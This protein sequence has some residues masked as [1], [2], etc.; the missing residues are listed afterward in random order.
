MIRKAKIADLTRIKKITEACAAALIDQGIYQWNSRYP[1]LAAFRKDIE[2]QNLYVYENKGAVIGCIMFSQ[3]KDPQYDSIH[4]LTD[5]HKNLYIHRLAVHPNSQKQGIAR[6]MMDFAEAFS[7]RE[8]MISIR[9]DTFSKN[10]RNIRFYKARGYTKL[11][12]VYF[13]K[14]SQ[15]PFHCFEKVVKRI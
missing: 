14:Q 10:P 4:W 7:I 1:S 2:E 9:L 11:G 3:E 8:K 15:D 6:Q 13:I 5:D 12:D